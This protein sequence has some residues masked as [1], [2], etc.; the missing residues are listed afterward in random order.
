MASLKAKYITEGEIL[1]NKSKDLWFKWMRYKDVKTAV[2]DFRA[3]LNMFTY[4]IEPDEEQLD[5]FY[6]RYSFIIELKSDLLEEYYKEIFGNFEE[7]E[8]L[9]DSTISYLQNELKEIKEIQEQNPISQTQR[10]Q[11]E[12]ERRLQNS[13]LTQESQKVALELLKEVQ[14][15]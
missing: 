8:Q 14:N 15:E 1:R 12:F 4:N 13:S 5:Y 3:L 7:E 10:I 9:T 6:N 11:E 2:N